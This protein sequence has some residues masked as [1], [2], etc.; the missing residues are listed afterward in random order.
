MKSEQL[1]CLCE[2]VFASLDR[3]AAEG[4][5]NVLLNPAG[6][7]ADEIGEYDARLAGVP[8]AVIRPLVAA[9]LAARLGPLSLLV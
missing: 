9:W 4:Y 6:E 3:A 8:T 7:T 1:L 5:D 2:R